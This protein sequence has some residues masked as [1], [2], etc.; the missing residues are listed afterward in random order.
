MLEAGVSSVDKDLNFVGQLMLKK[1]TSLP[2]FVL[3][4][5]CMIYTLPGCIKIS[6]APR[7][8]EAKH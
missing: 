3:C 7:P 8:D 6:K 4:I 5:S 1:Q 2:T